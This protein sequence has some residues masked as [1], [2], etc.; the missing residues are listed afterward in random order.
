MKLNKSITVSLDDGEGV[1]GAV[2]KAND[3]GT[4]P[5]RRRAI[6]ALFV[7]GM[8]A[9]LTACSDVRGAVTGGP[10]SSG[11]GAPARHVTAGRKLVP[12]VGEPSG[13]RKAVGSNDNIAGDVAGCQP[14]SLA[15]CYTEDTMQSYLDTVIPMVQD[16]FT[17]EYKAMPTPKAYIYIP[18]GEVVTAGCT[19]ADGTYTEDENSYAYCPVDG[20]VYLG[21]AEAWTLYSQD[22]DAA[23][24]IGLAHE[25]GH[26]VQTQVGVPAPTTD[27][28]HVVHEDQADC[29][30]GA[31]TAYAGTRGWLQ[32]EDSATV[33][34]LL[35][36]IASSEDDPNR[37]HGDLEERTSS[38]YEGVS[39]G[40]TGCDG[41]YP[42][43]PI[44]AS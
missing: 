24:A 8:L 25:W 39:T 19:N 18:V 41:F 13:A 44:L 16:F 3:A 31:W 29:V 21:Q 17:A 28:E 40:L 27:P 9:S 22:G 20:T 12:A 14:P 11:H 26:N 23:P 38:F 2:G 10:T 34:N 30:A 42:A 36:T 5:K 1:R 35:A 6:S 32:P 43:T 37:D 7:A 15:N 4:H 33:Q